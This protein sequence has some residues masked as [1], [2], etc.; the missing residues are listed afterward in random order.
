MNGVHDLGGMDGMGPVHPTAWEPV[1]HAEW[2]KAAF[3]FFPFCARAGMFG[4]DEFRRHLEQLHPVHYL[5]SW[6]YEHWLEAAEAIGKEKGFWTADELHERAAYYLEYPDA[7][8]P[9]HDDPALV[10]FAQWAVENGFP[11]QRESA[12]QAQFSVGDRVRIDN[13]MPRRHHRRPRYSM[14]QI[15]EIILHHGTHVFP[16]TTGNGKAETSEHLYTVKLRQ[17]DLF[18]EQDADP[19]ACQMVDMW[20]PYLSLATE[21]SDK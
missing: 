1:Y 6:Y 4:L 2:E 9:P 5:T 19:N 18:G 3:S 13:T 21:E 7:P 20:E 16:D 10:E 8:L 15:G 17:A 12:A 11:T 14:G